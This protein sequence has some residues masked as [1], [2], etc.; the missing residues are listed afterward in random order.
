M[1][2]WSREKEQRNFGDRQSE[3][4]RQRICTPLDH[5]ACAQAHPSFSIVTVRAIEV[6][7]PDKD[8]EKTILDLKMSLFI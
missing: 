7:S 4:Q 3:Q 2:T 8:K 1:F 6:T 5:L